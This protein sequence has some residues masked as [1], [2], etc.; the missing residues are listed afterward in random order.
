MPAHSAASSRRRPEQ[1]LLSP[2]QAPAAFAGGGGQARGN[3][4][5][6]AKLAAEQGLAPWDQKRAFDF[7]LGGDLLRSPWLLFDLLRG[8]TGGEA[9]GDAAKGGSL[10]AE[11]KG[12]EAA[13]RSGAIDGG[14]FT[15]QRDRKGSLSGTLTAA[16]GGLTTGLVG[17]LSSSG[18]RT[19]SSVTADGGERERRALQTGSLDGRFDRTGGQNAWGLNGLWT[20]KDAT[21]T[22][23]DTE[24]SSTTDTALREGKLKGALDS[25]QGQ[26]NGSLSGALSGER[27]RSIAEALEDGE[28]NTSLLTKGA[29]NLDFLRKGGQSSGKG[30]LGGLVDWSQTTDT[31]SGGHQ[32]STTHG[33]KGSV[34]SSIVRGADGTLSGGVDGGVGLST[35]RS[36]HSEEGGVTRDVDLALGSELTGGLS[37]DASGALLATGGLALDGS[38]RHSEL[39]KITG[40][41]QKTSWNTDGGLD[42]ALS[43]THGGE[44]SGEKTGSLSGRFGVGGEQSTR[45]VI[46]GVTAEDTRQGAAKLSGGASYEGGEWIRSGTAELSAADSH[47]RSST[48]ADGST[49]TETDASSAKA[50]G[51]VQNSAAGTVLRGSAGLESQAGLVTER[52]LSAD[53]KERAEDQRKGALSGRL[54]RGVDGALSGQVDGSYGVKHGVTTVTD[55]EGLH[56]ERSVTGGL[57]LKTSVVG[58]D[59]KLVQTNGAD[60]DLRFG[61]SRREETETGSV[62]SALSQ[63]VGLG[64]SQT[65]DGDQRQEALKARYGLEGSRSSTEVVDG[66]TNKSSINGNGSVTGGYS[67][68]ADGVLRRTGGVEV[69]G[70]LSNESVWTDGDTRHKTTSGL[71]LKGSGSVTEGRGADG[72]LTLGGGRSTEAVTTTGDTVT[73]ATTADRADLS[74]SGAHN[75]GADGVGTNSGS[76]SLG[77]GRESKTAAVTTGGDG[78]VRTLTDSSSTKG[79]GAYAQGT[80]ATVGLTHKVEHVDATVAGNVT[81]TSSDSR[82]T[83]AGYD[84]KTGLGVTQTKDHLGQKKVEALGT[85]GDTTLTTTKNAVSTTV[86]AGVKKDADGNTVATANAKANATLYGQEIAKKTAAGTTMSAGYK[87]GN[88][89]AQAEGKALITKDQIKVGGTAGA[90]V[91]LVEGNAKIEAPVFGWSMFGE[92]FNVNLSAGV[93]AAVLAEANGKID[94]D[95]SKGKDTLGATVKGGGHAFAG[96]KA[97]VEIGA[98]LQWKRRPDY[99]QDIIKFAKSI[100]GSVDDWLIDKLPE[101]FW[102]KFSSTVIGSGASK[103]VDARAGVTGS[104]GIGGDASF[105]FGLSGGKINVSGELSGTVG[106]GAGVSTDLQLDAVDGVRLVGVYGMR[107]LTYLSDKISGAGSWMWDVVQQLRKQ[108][109]DYMEAKKAEGGFSGGLA[110]VTDFFGDKVFNLW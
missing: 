105:G 1:A 54:E 58:R 19:E 72:K 29:A 47:R 2:D 87:V 70:G 108:V 26:T 10:K 93:S 104:A 62:E 102:P 49:R 30:S 96:A 67:R 45:T 98:A 73:T 52:R 11:A 46:D 18:K 50:S 6:L 94:L 78:S 103:I 80:G 79:T 71:D 27:S 12:T 25:S 60:A 69:G 107:G 91:S 95:I 42:A 41:T 68:D 9:G 34:A 66:R 56:D 32:R 97:G 64:V 37:R 21:T 65:L 89:E 28:R 59:G 24:T 48:G 22:K 92:D 76:V 14:T 51:G 74:L 55:R 57:G 99:S 23:T 86:G 101:D 84:K 33:A 100:P 17:S 15:E 77:L 38:S 53:S 36:D 44:Q 82:A 13:S 35:A 81:T 88:A 43:R 90:K 16:D 20:G 5:R 85:K 83:T 31:V 7:D 61:H 39:A 109:D 106:L 8:G 4:A 40:G 110:T 75:K 63:T 3:Q